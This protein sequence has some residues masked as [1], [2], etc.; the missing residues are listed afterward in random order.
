MMTPVVFLTKII[1]VI[2]APSQPRNLNMLILYF[3]VAI[4]K[5]ENGGHAGDYANANI[6]PWIPHALKIIFFYS[7]ANI[8]TL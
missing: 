2:S 6:N 4:L 7:F 8:Q 3:M 5:I 1:C